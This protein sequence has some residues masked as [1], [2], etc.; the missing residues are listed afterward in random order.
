MRWRFNILKRFVLLWALGG[1]FIAAPAPRAV[2]QTQ[3]DIVFTRDVLPVIRESFLPLLTEDTGLDASSWESLMQGSDQGEVVIPFDPD[4]SLLIER[5]REAGIDSA[6]LALAR[7][8]IERGAQNDDGDVPYADGGPFLYV[9]NQGSAVISVIDMQANVVVRTVDLRDFGFSENAKPHHVAV[10]PDGAFWYVSLIGEHAVLKFNRDNELVGR[11]TFEA[12]GML[13]FDSARNQ[14]YVGRSMS[15][16]NPPQR[17]GIIEPDSMAIEEIDVFHP[18]PHALNV[19]P[20]GKHVFS[21]SL[22]VNQIAVLNAESLDIELVPVPGMHHSLVQFAV[23]PNG[24]SMIVGG[25]MSGDV[26][27]LDITEPMQ[28]KVTRSLSLG[29]GP[30]HPSFL[31]N[32]DRVVFPAKMANAVAI[33]DAADG[34]EIANVAGRGVAEP[35]GSA[36]RPDGRYIYVSSNNLNA[37]FTPRYRQ[38]IPKGNETPHGGHAGSQD[39]SAHDRQAP[40]SSETPNGSVTVIDAD[41]FD[42]VKVIEVEQY[43]TG[44]GAQ[45]DVIAP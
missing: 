27:F 21:A 24:R 33:L 32:G 2:G 13:A 34:T 23:A 17:I 5:G 28:P 12:P 8:W 15:A 25:H 11:T 14:L 6:A 19:T 1:A 41:T 18:R 16:A 37:A 42:I 45:R 22:G 36:V 26:L 44:I 20:D 10:T 40:A 3:S 7:T 35:H 39:H 31:P 38:K 4:R 30:W 9:C 29:G 43:P